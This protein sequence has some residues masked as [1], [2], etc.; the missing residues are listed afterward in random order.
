MAIERSLARNFLLLWPSVADTSNRSEERWG[1]A[2]RG[3]ADVIFSDFPRARTRVCRRERTPVHWSSSCVLSLSVSAGFASYPILVSQARRAAVFL[4]LSARTHASVISQGLRALT[5]SAV[6]FV[7]LSLAPGQR[8]RW[9]GEFPRCT[10]TSLDSIP[11]ENTSAPRA[12]TYSVS[13]APLLIFQASPSTPPLVGRALHREYGISCERVE[14]VWR[15]CYVWKLCIEE[16]GRASFLCCSRVS[17]EGWERVLG[18]TCWQ[19]SPRQ[20]AWD[21]SCWVRVEGTILCYSLCS[22]EDREEK[23]GRMFVFIWRW[24]TLPW[25]VVSRRLFLGRKNFEF[26]TS[27]D[28]E[29]ATWNVAYFERHENWSFTRQ[30]RR[31][32]MDMIDCSSNQLDN[33]NTGLRGK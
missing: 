24:N 5:P 28:L 11:S 22:C 17:E 16:Q 15:E 12:H 21:F 8:P 1:C 4:D 9:V 2:T 7:P 29:Q 25:E 31:S 23:K 30:N 33:V 10:N 14:R 32:K 19:T 26:R 3:R 6:C 18:S 13:Q 20:V 27:W